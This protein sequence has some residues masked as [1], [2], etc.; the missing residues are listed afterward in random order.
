MH[1]LVM[2]SL[3]TA[4]VFAVVAVTATPTVA[5]PAPIAAWIEQLGDA[6]RVH[7]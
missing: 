2:R 7:C 3:L 6:G 5:P 4:A 1:G